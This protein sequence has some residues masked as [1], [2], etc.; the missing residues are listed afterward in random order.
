MLE[1]LIE[2]SRKTGL[3]LLVL[4]MLSTNARA[5]HVYEKVGFKEAGRV[6]K[7]GFTKEGHVN[8]IRMYLEL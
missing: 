5:R 4:D 6:P 8:V 3:K 7:M 1:T 2:E